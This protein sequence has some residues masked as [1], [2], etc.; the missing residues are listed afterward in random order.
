MSSVLFSSTDILNAIKQNALTVKRVV[1]SSS[2]ETV[3]DPM[4]IGGITYSEVNM[5]FL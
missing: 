4:R 5:T 1:I 3:V 2:I